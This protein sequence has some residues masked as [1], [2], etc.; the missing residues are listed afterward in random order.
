MASPGNQPGAR[1]L[2]PTSSGHSK[3]HLEAE[4]IG[5]VVGA[6]AVL[7][8][9][10]VVLFMYV[11]WR[12][13]ALSR[14]ISIREEKVYVDN[15]RDLLLSR[16]NKYSNSGLLNSLSLTPRTHTHF[17]IE[18][19]NK[20]TNGFDEK[21]ILG[22]G[23]FGKVYKGVLPIFPFTKVAIKALTG[24]SSQGVKEFVT[25]IE[26]LS[27]LDG[28]HLVRLLGSC[29]VGEQLYLVYRHVA[30]GS[31]SDHLHG[32]NR[33][34]RT[35][36]PWATRVRIALGAATGI[37]FL[38][39]QEP[40]VLHRD[41]KAANILLTRNFNAKVCDFGFAK[42]LSSGEES[43][44]FCC[45]PTLLMSGAVGT[46]GYLAPESMASGEITI[47]SDV[48]SFGVVMLELLT[49]RKPVDFSRPEREQSL[50]TWSRRYMEDG[51]IMELLDPDMPDEV[52][53]VYDN[54]RVYLGWVKSCLEPNP[55]NRPSMTL[56]VEGLGALRD[57]VESRLDAVSITISP[58]FSDSSVQSDSASV[59]SDERSVDE[60]SSSQFDD[61]NILDMEQFSKG[62]L[63]G[64]EVDEVE[65]ESKASSKNSSVQSGGSFRPRSWLSVGFN[66]PPTPARG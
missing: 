65:V 57:E 30:N 8:L 41:I 47:E 58:D 60:F 55:E 50:V 2:L 42:Q 46:V 10:F 9:F 38:H 37:K 51:R 23:G 5:S 26:L 15:N 13:R 4:I 40:P 7:V 22:E 20:A 63:D 32:E 56:V 52:S 43:L 59:T 45:T 1:T 53:Y 3:K 39:E 29:V 27:R 11:R 19:L 35:L 14:K 16:N 49:G 66:K 64:G 12:R 48:Y 21:Y 6:A 62:F 17:S 61:T 28:K 33:K 18:D 24:T 25:E 44:R 36:F 54:A 34:S 31:L